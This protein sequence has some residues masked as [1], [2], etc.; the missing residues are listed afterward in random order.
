MQDFRAKDGRYI[1]GP[2]SRFPAYPMQM[3]A[4]DFAR[5]AFLY[6]HG[7]NWAGTQVVP[8]AWVAESTHPWSNT[9]SGGYGY[10]WWTGDSASAKHHP[11]YVFPAGSF[12][13]EGHL[14]QY[15]VVVPSHD[16]IV[17]VRVAGDKPSKQVHKGDMAGQADSA[18]PLTRFVPK[19]R[20]AGNVHR[21]GIPFLNE[22]ALFWGV[23]RSADFALLRLP[24]LWIDEV[25]CR[26]A[27]RSRFETTHPRCELS[28]RAIGARYRHR[29][30][31]LWRESY[32]S[33][34]EIIYHGRFYPAGSGFSYLPYRLTCKGSCRW[35]VSKWK[36]ILL[37]QSW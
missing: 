35:R 8:A 19:S 5:F 22:R 4:R 30:F 24:Q 7:G 2:E 18:F 23:T 6:L 36:R 32:G 10:L 3:S 27:L 13:L 34:A 37:Q 17:V 28:Q 12:W 26:I 25:S 1:R 9:E 11:Q 16:L 14:G 31:I 21:S 33:E 20:V 29:Q 15:A